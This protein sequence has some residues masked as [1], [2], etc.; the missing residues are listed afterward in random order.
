[1]TF[2]FPSSA[3]PISEDG[4]L[5]TKRVL[6]QLKKRKKQEKVSSSKGVQE[7]VILIPA[8]FDVLLG[9]EMSSQENLGNLPYRN[10][11]AAYQDRSETA[12]KSKK[13]V[14]AN[15]V[16]QNII[17]CLGQFLKEYDGDFVEISYARACKKVSHSFRSLRHNHL[18]KIAKEPSYGSNG[19]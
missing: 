17:K 7:P 11:I 16:V 14:I 15:E 19:Q 3:L 2:G 1:M 6:E 8:P 5:K 13:T 10:L 18:R 4:L 9:R 12:Q